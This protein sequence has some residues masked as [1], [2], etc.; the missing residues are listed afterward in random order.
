VGV[1]AAHGHG[2]MEVQTFE[3]LGGGLEYILR[4]PFMSGEV[5]RPAGSFRPVRRYLRSAS[6]HFRRRISSPLIRLVN[7]HAD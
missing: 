5:D 4:V 6:R 3:A 7:F 1:P 2:V